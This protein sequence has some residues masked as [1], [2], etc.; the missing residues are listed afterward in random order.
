MVIDGGVCVRVYGVATS[1]RVFRRLKRTT[2]R[3]RWRRWCQRRQRSVAVVVMAVVVVVAVVVATARAVAAV[4]RQTTRHCGRTT[5]E[6][7]RS[8]V[9]RN[10]HAT[11]MGTAG[12]CETRTS[13]VRDRIGA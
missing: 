12:E 9:Q 8:G 3:Q 2:K 6:V 5:S 7:S 11:P 10:T 13:A 1:R 4:A